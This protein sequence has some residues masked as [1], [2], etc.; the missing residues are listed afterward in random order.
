MLKW[1]VGAVA[2]VAFFWGLTAVMDALAC[3]GGWENCSTE[4]ILGVIGISL[5]G[6]SFVYL[7]FLIGQVQ[8]SF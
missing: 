5:A 2:A 3:Q 6:L 7:G 4:I 8:K 1:L